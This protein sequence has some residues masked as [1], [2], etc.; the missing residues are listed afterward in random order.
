M[1]MAT[2][3]T[4]PVFRP[5][6]PRTDALLQYLH[7]ID[8]NRIYSNFG[9]LTVEF[10]QRLTSLLCTPTGSLSCASSGT[11]ALV[12]AILASAGRANQRPLAAIPSYTFP[13]TAAAAE[14][15]GYTPMLFDISA[16]DWLLHPD[17]V[18]NDPKLDQ[19]GVVI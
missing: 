9:P 8:A 6:L 17:T 19:I 11:V 2:K 18:L 16:D 10:E 12:G 1:R 13:A 7:R 4:L 3:R 5:Q 15:C 14:Q